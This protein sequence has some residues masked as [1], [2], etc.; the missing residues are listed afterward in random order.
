MISN[1]VIESAMYSLNHERKMDDELIKDIPIYIL[2]C[3]VVF[4]WCRYKGEE[5][6]GMLNYERSI[7]AHRPM[8]DLAYCATK[9]MNGNVLKTVQFTEKHFKPS[10]LK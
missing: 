4:G 6:F 5:M 3:P 9:G 1:I 7:K 2:N 8:I 10:Q